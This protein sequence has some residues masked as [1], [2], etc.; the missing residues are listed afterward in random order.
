[1][2]AA[3]KE[4]PGADYI[5]QQY[6]QSGLEDA[7]LSTGTWAPVEA[8]P[9]ANGVQSDDAK[10]L[11]ELLNGVKSL[12]QVDANLVLLCIEHDSHQALAEILKRY[13]SCLREAL[14]GDQ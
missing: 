4:R 2:L 12:G 13:P 7:A 10:A 11:V 8:E 5:Y 3:L 14:R 1:M 9:I 6:S